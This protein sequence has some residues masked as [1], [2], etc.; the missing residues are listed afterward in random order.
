M[1]E[2]TGN[3]FISYRRSQVD[4]V[5]GLVASLHEHGIPTWRDLTDLRTEPTQK[6]LRRV[7]RDSSTS[8]GVV[9]VSQDTPKSEIILELELPELHARWCDNEDFYVVVALCPG[10]DYDE[11]AEILD[12]SPRVRD[13]SPWNMIKLRFGANNTV[14]FD[15]VSRTLLAERLRLIHDKREADQSLQCSLDTYGSRSYPTPLDLTIDWSHHFEDDF[16]TSGVWDNRLLPALRNVIDQVEQKAPGRQLRFRGQ[17]LIPATFAL[18]R[19]LRSTRNI[20]ASWLQPI[21]NNELEPWSLQ[22]TEKATGLSDQLD[23]FDVTSSHL[24]VLL[25]ITNDVEPAVGRTD[26]SL[27]D[28]GGILHLTLDD[29]LGTHLSAQQAKNVANIFREK[30]QLALNDLTATSK[31]HLFM[32]IP[33]GLSFLLGQQTNTFPA[34][35]TYVLET[36]NGERTYQ[37]GPVLK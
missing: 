31:I 13:F 5:E 1:T 7:I 14:A 12:Q 33:T 37:K 25:S 2:I 23:V 20:D 28:F 27:P 3:T 18:G 36:S 17:A 30:V 16:P 26:A 21:G 15:E 35:Q 34:I 8:S 32:A 29:E 22:T 19:V 6:E 4:I 9:V 24:A 10:V 11:A